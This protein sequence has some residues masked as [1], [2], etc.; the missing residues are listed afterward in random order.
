M[1]S[2][3]EAL[4]N[5]PFKTN[6]DSH[7][8]QSCWKAWEQSPALTPPSL[9][10][11]LRNQHCR[12]TSEISTRIT[13]QKHPLF[14]K[15]PIPPNP[16]HIPGCHT[17]PYKCCSPITIRSQNKKTHRWKWGGELFTAAKNCVQVPIIRNLREKNIPGW[18]TFSSSFIFIPQNVTFIP[19]T[20]N[21]FPY[22][23]KDSPDVWEL[24]PTLVDLMQQLHQNP[25]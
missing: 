18:T 9:V 19:Q 17:K 2:Q 3:P 5:A 13:L 14:Y 25:Y 11:L 16:P 21:I 23:Q 12:A 6:L 24:H 8:S 20:L 10:G 1:P 7:G 22:N 4:W 15:C